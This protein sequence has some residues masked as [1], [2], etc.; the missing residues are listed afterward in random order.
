MIPVTC[1]PLGRA[2]F[3]IKLCL[4]PLFEFAQQV[5]CVFP[6]HFPCRVQSH[7]LFLRHNVVVNNEDAVTFRRDQRTLNGTF[8]FCKPSS[9]A[10]TSSKMGPCVSPDIDLPS[11]LSVSVSGWS[12]Q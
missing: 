3:W 5:R 9:A 2:E 6:C 4:D 7:N 11:L 10:F 8:S 12:G 1:A